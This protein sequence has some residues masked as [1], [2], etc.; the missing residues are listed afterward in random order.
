MKTINDFN[1]NNKKALVRVDFNVPQSA[2]LKVT[3]KSRI[4]AVKPTIDKILN[5]GGSV[6]LMTHLGRP[7]GK[8]SEE[9]SLKNI[10][11]EIE[12]VLGK[13]VQFCPDC[14]GEDA[15]NLTG[16][17][18][19]GEILLLENLRFY[20]EE[21]SG[22]KAFAE[23]LSKYADVYVND[24]FG[25]A[26][27]EHAST[28]VIAQY[29][30]STKFFGLLMAK[31]LEAID[32]VLKSG[33]KPVTAILG[34]SKVS[35]KI[36]I[37]ENILPAIDHLIIGGGMAFTFVKALGGKVGNSLVE[38]DKLQLALEILE[39]AKEQ[40]VK[41]HLPIDTIIANEF[42]NDADFREADIFDIPEG[43]MGLDAGKKSRELNHDVLMN[44]RT[45]LW[46]GPI[47][48]FEMPNFSAGTIALGDSIAESTKLGAFSLV[49][50]GDS[51]AF[52]KKFGYEEKVSY[53]STGGGAML[54]S[55]EGLELPG[56][57]AI[58]N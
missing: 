45:I 34:G 41:V 25:T 14:M 11:S 49:G 30:P 46:N 38:E 33:E 32:K 9:F 54:E 23:K 43:W 15:I 20:N 31:E 2:D 12:E 39:K 16:K 19:P 52:V 48:V 50:G 7:K 1:F 35:T 3:D 18:A 17:L 8:V 13:E 42:S 44:S 36:T 56:V 37:I 6:I 5:D 47:G 4:V 22:D 28:A 29:F 24:A 10:V 21:E 53:V 58:N 26:H 40:K 51:V 27:R 55:L 57:K